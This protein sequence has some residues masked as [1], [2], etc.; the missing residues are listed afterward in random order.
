MPSTHE[1]GQ[2][3]ATL[4]MAA[5]R[6]AEARSDFDR[7][8]RELVQHLESA[9]SRWSGRGATAFMAL[10][11]AWSER[12]RTIIAALDGFEA[13]LR[14]TETDNTTTDDTQSAAFTRSRQRLG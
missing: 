8:D 13:A 2:G 3:E 7:L 6:V 4:S 12:Q 5:G 14:S 9:R 10:G 11:L 1:M